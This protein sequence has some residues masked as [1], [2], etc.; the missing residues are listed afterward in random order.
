M[1]GLTIHRFL[2]SKTKPAGDST[3]SIFRVG[4]DDLT[5]I[6]QLS[7]SNM[8]IIDPKNQL[9]KLSGNLLLI[10][11]TETPQQVS[12]KLNTEEK[13]V[14]YVQKPL[15]GYPQKLQSQNTNFED[16]HRD[17]NF[18]HPPS[19]KKLFGNLTKHSNDPQNSTNYKI[20]SYSGKYDDYNIKETDYQISKA[21]DFII[22]PL[23]TLM[24]YIESETP[25]PQLKHQRS[26]E[27]IIKENK[28]LSL[29]KKP[30]SH[31]ILK[32]IEDK[33]TSL[34]VLFPN[35]VTLDVNSTSN[36]K[37]NI[38]NL[39]NPVSNLLELKT[40]ST[41]N[42]NK[43][44]LPSTGKDLSYGKVQNI[45]SGIRDSGEPPTQYLTAD[46]SSALDSNM[47]KKNKNITTNLEYRT[48]EKEI[49]K[50]KE[51]HKDDNKI[52][53]TDAY[54]N[55]N[56]VTFI[57]EIESDLSNKEQVQLLPLQQTFTDTANDYFVTQTD[58]HNQTEQ[59]S[60]ISNYDHYETTN[61]NDQFGS[62]E[63][64]D[65]VRNS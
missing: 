17:L 47:F 65:E 48:D 27:E 29:S 36:I 63:Q 25:M 3:S 21:D 59:S 8:K 44:S 41:Y 52:S 42:P 10:N 14:L 20:E 12:S 6:F 50:P 5:N 24:H 7:E 26:Q 2:E 51:F 45:S 32:G 9:Q 56:N 22:N 28:T 15:K 31:F 11:L 62:Q 33:G 37:N 61:S 16:I 39:R 58:V 23:D 54:N 1:V 64:H 19:K 55:A 40:E 46:L 4:P 43:D 60:E 18:E 13:K 38:S 30:A 34:D 53:S 49:E 35:N 57:S